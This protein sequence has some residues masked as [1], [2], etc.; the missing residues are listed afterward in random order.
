VNSTERVHIALNVRQPDRVPVVEFVIDPKVAALAAAGCRD[1][2]DC[3]DR[4]DMD[5]VACGAQF[6][7]TRENAD[8]SYQDEW[9]VTCRPNPEAVAHSVRGVIRTL[10]DAPRC[11]VS[12]VMAFPEC[13]HR[14]PFA[15][16]V[17]IVRGS[18]LSPTKA[19]PLGRRARIRRRQQ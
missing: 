18:S 10:A 19:M 13:A 3:M 8:G 16:Y 15:T 4:L 14:D 12:V 17:R 1:A 2:A 6:R 9:G 5:A 7:R 11:R